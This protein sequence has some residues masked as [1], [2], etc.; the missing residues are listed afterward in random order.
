MGKFWS[1]AMSSLYGR[2]RSFRKFRNFALC[3]MH[4]YICFKNARFVSMLQVKYGAVFR[5]VFFFLFVYRGGKKPTLVTSNG[6]DLFT[7]R[8]HI[9]TPVMK[10]YVNMIYYNCELKNLIYRRSS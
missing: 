7:G 6:S 5:P 8:Q 9:N 10:K 4:K 2:G 3:V 1:S